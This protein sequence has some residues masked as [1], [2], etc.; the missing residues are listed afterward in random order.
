MFELVLVISGDSSVF[1]F[2]HAL[3]V[4]HAHAFCFLVEVREHV[5]LMLARCLVAV[6]DS[7]SFK[8]VSVYVLNRCSVLSVLY[9]KLA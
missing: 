5:V 4:L 1:M 8:L 2:C 9:M 7:L 6:L 3:P